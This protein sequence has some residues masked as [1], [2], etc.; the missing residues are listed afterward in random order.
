MKSR[1][2]LG[3]NG[4]DGILLSRLLISQGHHLIGI[5]VQ[6]KTVVVA[7]DSLIGLWVVYLKIKG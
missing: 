2:I 5:G 3:V 6:P 4:Q 1:L 7:V